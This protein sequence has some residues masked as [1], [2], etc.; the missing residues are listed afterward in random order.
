MKDIRLPSYPLITCDPYFSLWSPCDHLYDEDPCHWAGAKKPVLGVAEIDGVPYRFMGAGEPAAV[1]TQTGTELQPTSTGYQFAAAGVEL[2]VRFTT[3]LLFSDLELISRPCTYVDYRA[4]STD[5]KEHC[6][7]VSLRFSEEHCHDASGHEPMICTVHKLPT[8]QA[9]SM[10]KKKQAPLSNSGDGITIDWGFL[11]LAVPN[12]AE[13]SVGYQNN[14]GMAY[15]QA[16]VTLRANEEG[17]SAYVICAYDDILSI[18]YFNQ[19]CKAYWARDGRRTI[20]DAIGDSVAHHNMLLKKCEVF[21]EHLVAE[22]TETVGEEYAVLCAAAYR[23][24]IAAHKLIAD[25]EGKPVFLSKENFSNGCIATVDVSYPSSPLYLLYA[26]ELVRGMM[27][28][29]F[30]FA[31]T[32]VWGYDFAP[33]DVG[34]YP[35]CTGQVYGLARPSEDEKENKRIDHGDIFPMYCNY[36][37]GSPIYEHKGQMPV[38]ECGN[39]LIMTAAAALRDGDVSFIEENI[40]LLEQWVCYLLEYGSDPGE[41]LCTDDFAGFLAH[42][43]NLSAKAIAGIAAYAIILDMLDREQESFSYMEKAIAMAQDWEKRAQAGDHTALSFANKDSWSLK[44]N[45]VWDVL[46]GTRLFSK[47]T[48][49]KEIA[50][51]QKVQNDYGVPLDIRADY[52]KPEWII[53]CATTADDPKDTLNL[54]KPIRRYLQ[55]TPTRV[56]FSD[57]YGTKDAKQVNFQNRSVIGGVFMPLLKEEFCNEL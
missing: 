47:E 12:C 10:G 15:A 33:H 44:Y 6:V 43:I 22:A 9:V 35:Y 27:R 29:V 46:F 11:Y 39:M 18:M 40:D 31:R 42:N 54:I 17:A 7:K 41:Q 20:F 5:G 1:M 34:R 56:P 37:A 38:E 50:W 25:E 24:S 49:Q 2:S 52:T 36:P 51:Y 26:P 45:L 21:D 3:P 53:W 57:W 48:Y 32:P 23:Q 16:D 19:A 30:R 28:P 55:E 13:G 4:V 8:Y 14:G